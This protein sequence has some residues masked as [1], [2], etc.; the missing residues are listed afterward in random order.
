M[1]KLSYRL[2]TATRNDKKLFIILTGNTHF[3]KKKTLKIIGAV[4]ESTCWRLFQGTSRGFWQERMNQQKWKQLYWLTVISPAL[5]P[6]TSHF[7]DIH[8]I[9][10]PHQFCVIMMTAVYGGSI[11]GKF[12]TRTDSF[13]SETFIQSR[14]PFG[15][16]FSLFFSISNPV[17]PVIT[18]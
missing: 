9:Q 14:A 13:D 12:S 7:V 3:F 10:N 15:N 5:F 11:K 6:P 2:I 1:T 8:A 17:K 18:F 4:N 16:F